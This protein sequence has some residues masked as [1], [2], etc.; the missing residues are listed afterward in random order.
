MT[1]YEILGVERGSTP[2]E[3]KT[4]YRKLA[5]KFHPDN[6]KDDGAAD[7]FREVQQAYE[8]LIPKP[9]QKSE[10]SRNPFEDFGFSE[11][12]FG[13]TFN[14][15]GPRQPRNHDLQTHARI[16]LEQAYNGC[17]ITVSN[18]DRIITVHLPKGIMH[19]QRMRIEGEGG[20]EHA[21]L[22]FGDLYVMVEI[23][24]HAIFQYGGIDLQTVMKID[25]LDL[26]TGCEVDMKTISGET[27]K[28]T[29][30]PATSPQTRLRIEGKGM[31]SRGTAFGDLYVVFEVIMPQ[32]SDEHRDEIQKIKV[33]RNSSV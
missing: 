26:I 27:V 8:T 32:L 15:G 24:Q 1:P 22:P 9:N 3:I 6:N 28:V 4:A 2:E 16:T 19:G 20:R 7:K 12:P 30:P 31:P 17:D 14:F 10:D 21:D 29:V 18:G 11:G 5:M 25:V 23:M 33:A 13:W